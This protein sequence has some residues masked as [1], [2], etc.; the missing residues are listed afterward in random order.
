MLGSST[1]N[2]AL[3]NANNA[4]HRSTFTWPLQ[5]KALLIIGSHILWTR[6]ATMFG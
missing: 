1:E 6:P 2:N 4:R 3:A 5:Y